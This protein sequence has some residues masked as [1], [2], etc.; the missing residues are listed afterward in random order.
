VPANR[1]ESLHKK[2]ITTYH[3][4][5]RFTS[6][7]TLEINGEILTA[8]KFVLANGAKPMKLSIPGEELVIDSTAFLDLEGLPEEMLLIGG[9]YIAFEFGHLAARLGAKVKIIHR[10][11]MP[12]KNF[13]SDL[14]K[15]LVKVTQ[16]L[17]IEVMLNTEVKGISQENGQLVV[18]ATA[19]GQEKQFLTSL[20]VHAAGRDADI[21]DLQL[22]KVNVDF[23]R[24]GV[25]VNEYMQSVSNPNVYAIGDVNDRGLQL[26]PVAGK[27]RLLP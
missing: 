19:D 14:V 22:E 16:D 2:G 4:R 11:A 3:G 23:G 12:L 21:D 7:N 1:E 18:Q 25:E 20:V 13:E 6:E 17:G 24:K 8:E 27:E 26:T 15:H 10:G 9:G 5:A